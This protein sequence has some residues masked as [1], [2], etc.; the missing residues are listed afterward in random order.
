MRDK[1]SEARLAFGVV[2]IIVTISIV[3]I[4]Q[5]RPGVDPPTLVNLRNCH[6]PLC[7]LPHCGEIRMAVHVWFLTVAA[8]ST[9]T[10]S[11][12]I[13]LLLFGR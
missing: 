7:H 2:I 4:S 8:A 6:Y 1:L 5:G 9:L 13:V 12:A 3:I 11:G 10:L